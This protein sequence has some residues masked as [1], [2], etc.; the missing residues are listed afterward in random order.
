MPGRPPGDRARYAAER[1][2]LLA[3]RSD[4]QTAGRTGDHRAHVKALSAPGGCCGHCA[5]I[6]DLTTAGRRGR[7]TYGDA[8]GW[9]GCQA[10]QPPQT[11]EQNKNPSH[12]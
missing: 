6:H 5:L 1:E 10:Y 8:A 2:R 3:G 11:G 9:C 7:C 4:P 12:D